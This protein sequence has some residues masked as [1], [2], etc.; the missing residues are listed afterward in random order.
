VH[1]TTATIVTTANNA[2]A[3]PIVTTMTPST[4]TMAKW[5]K[6]KF[7]ENIEGKLK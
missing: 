5:E 3:I 7:S 4:T 1:T 6:V 2:T